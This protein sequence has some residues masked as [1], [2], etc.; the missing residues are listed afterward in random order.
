MVYVIYIGGLA[1]LEHAAVRWV[2]H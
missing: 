2:A 1:Y